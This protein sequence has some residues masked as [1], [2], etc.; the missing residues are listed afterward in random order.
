MILASFIWSFNFLYWLMMAI[1]NS[2]NKR[3]NDENQLTLA[4]EAQQIK[5]DI[6][7]DNTNT[8]N[9]HTTN[10]HTTNKHTNNNDANYNDNNNKQR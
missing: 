8:T 5:I 10:K 2:I 7:I 4:P 3:N 6:N 1:N 9:K